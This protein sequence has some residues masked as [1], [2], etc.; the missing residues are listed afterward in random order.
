M[1]QEWV[2][3]PDSPSAAQ[4][5]LNENTTE[6]RDHD[7]WYNADR[8][9]YRYWDM[10]EQLNH[11]R[12]LMIEGMD[13]QDE[14]L[15]LRSLFIQ[16]YEKTKDTEYGTLMNKMRNISINANNILDQIIEIRTWQCGLSNI[17]GEQK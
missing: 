16:K 14:I 6:D 8:V 1:S 15:E 12:R 7:T 11:S 3:I 13:L 4:E 17:F 2:E 5:T 9:P 10:T